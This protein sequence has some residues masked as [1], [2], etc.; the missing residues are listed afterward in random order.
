MSDITDFVPELLAVETGSDYE[1]PPTGLWQGVCYSVIDLW[2]QKETF[3]GETKDAHKVRIGFEFSAEINAETGEEKVFTIHKEFTLSFG[4]RSKLRQFIDSWNGGET[5]MTNEEAKGFNVF[6][7]LGK[8]VSL[9]IVEKT[10]AKNKKYVDIS[11]LSPRIKKIAL[12][13]REKENTYL[14]LNEKYFNEETFD[15]L[16]NFIKEKIQLSPEY[17]KM[18]WIETLDEQESNMK[19]EAKTTVTVADAQNVFGE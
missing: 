17:K 5:K 12:H 13:T 14:L 1:M 15:K 6:S 4:G 9:N 18:Y 2:T 8:E 10:S 3:E 19:E 11:S 7:L 16:P